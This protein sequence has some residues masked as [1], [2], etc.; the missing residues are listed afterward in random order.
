M[1]VGDRPMVLGVLER[2]AAIGARTILST[3][4]DPSDDE[5]ADT[6][7]R[8]GWEVKRGDLDDVL[9]R[10]VR[11]LPV[12]ARYVVR[13]TADCPLFD[14]RIGRT[15]VAAVRGGTVDYASNVAPP[16]FPDGLD[17]EAF[18]TDALRRAWREATL[19]SHREFTTPYLREHPELFRQW[20]LTHVPDLSH[21]RW[22]VDDERDLALIR[23]IEQRLPP[24]PDEATS[25]YAVLAILEREPGLR[26]LNAG[27]RRNEGAE[28][29]YA[30]ERERGAA[31]RPSGSG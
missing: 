10:S 2:A 19:P 15:L 16:T 24:D 22:T 30:R 20:N 21:H 13:V 23:A 17:C 12:G 1:P 27:T 26:T 18:T 14:P 3:S 7:A 6:A 29:A 8:H 31:G 4:A 28:R 9:D 11:A 25:M 5:L